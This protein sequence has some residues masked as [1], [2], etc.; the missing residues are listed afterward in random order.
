MNEVCVLLFFSTFGTED[1]TCLSA[2]ILIQNGLIGYFEA[3]LTCGMGIFV[4]DL[5]LYGIGRLAKRVS[6][7]YLNNWKLRSKGYPQ[8]SSTKNWIQLLFASRF[9]PGTRTMLY[10]SAGFTGFSLPLFALTLGT[11]ATL[12]V[13][14]LVWVAW[15]WGFQFQEDLVLWVYSLLGIILFLIIIRSF[16][17]NIRKPPEFWSS[18]FL[19]FFFVPLLLYL[20]V[21]HRGWRWMSTSNLCIAF[22]GIA[23]E[24][25][26]EIFQNCPDPRIPKIKLLSNLPIM[27]PDEILSE[28]SFPFILKPDSGERGVGVHLIRNKNDWD[29]IYP[30]LGEPYLAQDYIEGPME[31]GIFYMRLPWEDKGW[32][33]AITQKI[34]PKL[35]G[36]GKRSIRDLILEHPRFRWQASLFLSRLAESL[37]TISKEGESISL[38]FAGNHSQGCEFRDGKHLITEELAEI[39]D[40]IAKKWDGYYFGRWDVRFK[41]EESLRRGEF[42]ILEINGATSEATIIY[43]PDFSIWKI[44]QTLFKQWEYLFQ[45]GKWN[46]LNKNPRL[47]T[48]REIFLMLLEHREHIRKIS[49]KT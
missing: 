16:L 37:D 1:G 12:W 7:P 8:S 34:F 13:P 9:L 14:G 38:G 17:E 28:F 46:A 19:Y 11:A 41:E 47:I 3:C 36:D 40:S 25:K 29:S 10:F 32:I 15:K 45:I 33:F 6:I 20:A 30:T 26:F 2:G 24:S 23:G 22:G 48:Y 21:K 44:Y 43:D 39:V 4:G 27:H 49:I 35:I 31:A 42:S 5:G 18:S